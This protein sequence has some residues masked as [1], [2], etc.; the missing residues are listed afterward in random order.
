MPTAASAIGYELISV[1]PKPYEDDGGGIRFPPS[2]DEVTPDRGAWR[3]RRGRRALNP[4]AD[5]KVS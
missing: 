3:S 5:A 1:H 4:M 2:V